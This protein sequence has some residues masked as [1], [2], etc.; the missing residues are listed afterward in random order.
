LH[1]TAYSFDDFF[2]I[3]FRNPCFVDLA[4]NVKPRNTV[5]VLGDEAI[6]T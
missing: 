2:G 5:V 1:I 6:K 3:P 4:G